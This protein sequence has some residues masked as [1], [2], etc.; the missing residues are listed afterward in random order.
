LQQDLNVDAHQALEALNARITKNKNI[1]FNYKP[2]LR[3]AAIFAVVFSIGLFLYQ[4]TIGSKI[5]VS[6][7]GNTLVQQ[8]PDGSTATLNKQSSIAFVGGLF[9]ETRQVKLKGEAFFK[10][11]TDRRKPF[12]IEVDDVKVTVVGTAFN[13][14]NEGKET[15]V[16]VESGIVM[17]EGNNKRVRLVAG[18]KAEVKN[19]Q[20]TKGENLG[21]LYQYYY[22][23]VLVCDRTPL[24]ELVEVLRKKFNANIVIVN[25][26]ITDL[27]TTFEDNSLDDILRVIAETL[28]VR[29]VHEGGAIKLK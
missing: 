18:E 2:L 20:L 11:S 19:N 26:A 15:V 24:H 5:N 8:L 21:S 3:W 13:V 14:K 1:A 29:V 12:I 25:P 16:S 27:S 28:K 22:S 23:D 7:T 4:N 10:V 6:T 9:H 17:V